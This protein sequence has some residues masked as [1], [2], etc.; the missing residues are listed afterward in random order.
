MHAEN[1]IINN[2]YQI[3]EHIGQ[4]SFGQIYKAINIRTGEN[5][6]VK[7]ELISS[8]LKLL[9]NECIVYQYL[10]HVD[11]IPEF[12]WFGKDNEYYYMVLTLLGKSVYDVLLEQ[13]RLPWTAI[14]DIAIQII[15]IL[16]EVHDKGLIHRDIK[17]ENFLFGLDDESGKIYMIDFGLCKPFMSM[18]LQQHN[19]IKQ[20]TNIIGTPTY[21]SINGHKMIELSRRDDLESLGYMLIHLWIGDLKW[22]K[23]KLDR[24]I[25]HRN[26]VICAAKEKVGQLYTLPPPLINYLSYVRQLEYEERPDYEYLKQLFNSRPFPSLSDEYETTN[27]DDQ[28]KDRRR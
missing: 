20:T 15:S 11:G 6:A 19:E 26:N 25:V 2:K 3:I 22:R 10:L 17:P 18:E 9:K 4:G 8:N 23:I 5:I 1:T 14:T 21:V 24:D 27:C 13:E 28:D 16:Q 7:T 12:K